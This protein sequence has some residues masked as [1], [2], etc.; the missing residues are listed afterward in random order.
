MRS[1]SISQ[2]KGVRYVR[3]AGVVRFDDP[4]TGKRVSFG[5][6]NGG[7]EGA[8][9]YIDAALQ[10]RDALDG[11]MQ[12]G[13]A[14]NPGGGGQT[15]SA[16][17]AALVREVEAEA[18]AAG[19]LDVADWL[20]QN[21]AW[22]QQRTGFL[23]EQAGWAAPAAPAAPGRP[24]VVSAQSFV[25]LVT[26]ELRKAEWDVTPRGTGSP[27]SD[28]LSVAWVDASGK[29]NTTQ[30]VVGVTTPGEHEWA[31]IPKQTEDLG[32]KALVRNQ[33]EWK[34]ASELF[35][36]FVVH[37]I[38]SLGGHK[39]QTTPDEVWPFRFP[40]LNKNNTV[41]A[42]LVQ[43]DSQWQESPGA[44]VGA[45]HVTPARWD[46]IASGL[47]STIP[48]IAGKGGSRKWVLGKYYRLIEA[49][50]APGKPTLYIDPQGYDYARYVGFLPKAGESLDDVRARYRAALGVKHTPASKPKA[51]KPKAPTGAK[52]GA[53]LSSTPVPRWL[54]RD[55]ADLMEHNN[56]LIK[57]FADHFTHAW[58]KWETYR[59][60]V[61]NY[62]RDEGE[63]GFQRLI[64]A[65]SQNEGDAR[66]LLKKHYKGKLV[67]SVFT[68]PKGAKK[69]TGLVQS[70]RV[71]P[72]FFAHKDD[73]DRRYLVETDGLYALGPVAL[74]P[75]DTFPR[76]ERNMDMRG[77]LKSEY[78][79]QR[80]YAVIPNHQL[81]LESL[82]V[83]GYAA[84]GED[85]SRHMSR[86]MRTPQEVT[87]MLKHLDSVE[88][89]SLRF[90]WI[91]E[92]RD[93][94]SGTLQASIN[95]FILG[96]LQYRM[97]PLILVQAGE[98]P[99]ALDPIFAYPLEQT[100]VQDGGPPQLESGD[101]IAV[102]MPLRTDT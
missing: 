5:H 16:K 59:T 2:Y 27:L 48:E 79:S 60:V 94:R 18:R 80:P 13:I 99:Y 91:F 52:P 46:E 86:A 85:E 69:Y 71:V 61:V 23:L 58:L 101:K 82:E 50:Y 84:R 66:R 8:K 34:E 74:L 32:I 15:I 64:D 68:A 37:F 40:S 26:Q 39:D 19:N 83:S 65:H 62:L 63:R 87:D 55:D 53:S 93:G 89:D 21:A 56:A 24:Y 81:R 73:P 11:A 9:A 95:P 3:T 97:G 70:D 25:K 1:N 36:A 10:R 57:A 102:I 44:V 96:Y 31:I 76:G 47:L 4:L 29:E 14:A 17:A 41:E 49:I 45:T 33:Q 78:F 30:F 90:H 7:L 6:H 67:G 75:R 42:Y 51:P 77:V 88:T 38:E 72:A 28:L 35:A 98:S 22:A 92:G 43:A 54:G 100:Y 20:R 12:R